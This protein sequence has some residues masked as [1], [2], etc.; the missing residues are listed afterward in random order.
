MVASWFS[1]MK[2]GT[3][4]LLFAFAIAASAIAQQ[5]PR[6]AQIKVSPPPDVSNAVQLGHLDTATPLH[7]TVSLPY[8]DPGGMQRFVDSVSDPRNPNYR[9]F[10]TPEQIGQRFGLPASVVAKV[11]DYLKANGMTVQLVAKNHLTVSANCTVAQAETAFHTTIRELSAADVKLK[12]GQKLYSFTTGLS[13]PV[14]IAPYIIDVSGLET[15]TRPHAHA[16][17]SPDQ[18]R[19]L[20]GVAPTYAAKFQGKG[21]TVGITSFDGFELSNV[22]LLYQQFSL[23]TPAGGVGS[24]IKVETSNASI[25]GQNGP[26]QGEGDLDIQC[27]LSMASLCNLI[28]YDGGN[29]AGSWDPTGILALEA[30]DNTCDAISES[31]LWHG[32]ASFYTTQHNHHLAFNAQG[33]TYMACSGDHG[34][35]G[36]AKLPYPSMD[37]EIL[38]VGGTTIHVDATGNRISETAWNLTNELGD[39]QLWG[40]GG[41]WFPST[42]AFNVTPPYQKGKGVPTSVPFRLVPDVALDADFSYEI[43]LNGVFQPSQGIAWGGTSAATPTFTGSL[44]DVEERLISVNALST[45]AN[46]KQRLGRINDLLYLQNGNANVLFDI[47]TGNIGALPDGSTAVAT[48]GWDFTSG[49]GA[50]NFNGLYNLLATPPTVKA[51]TIAPGSVEGGS[52]TATGT[53]TLTGPALTDSFSVS[54]KSSS[55]LAQVP[56]KVTLGFGATSIP[57]TIKTKSV[58]SST[59]VTITATTGTVSKTATLT[60]TPPA[61]SA[62]KVVPTSV[63]GGGTSVGTVSIP[64]AAPVG[65]TVVTLTSGNSAATVPA[66][67]TIA[68]GSESA[69][70]NVTTKAVTASTAVKISASG[71]GKTATATL[72]LLPL[73][74]TGLTVSATSLFAKGVVTGTVKISGAA[75]ATGTTV[76]LTLSNAALGTLSTTGVKVAAGATSVTFTFTAKPV[77]ASTTETIK[78]TLGG[79]SK[80]ASVTIKPAILSAVTSSATSVLGGVQNATITFTLNA[81]AGPSGTVVTVKSSS[82]AATFAVS[83]VKVASGST[84]AKL[85]LTS[86]GVAS[87]TNVTV[88]G[89]ATASKTVVVKVTAALLTAFTITPSS[90]QGNGTKL[91]TGKLTLNGPTGAT[92]R[93]VT[94]TSSSASA[95]LPA[96]VSIPAGAKTVSFTFAPKAVAATTTATL[97]AKLASVSL[98][99]SLTITH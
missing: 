47:T 11:S 56:A 98:T 35:P 28:V 64:E 74:V 48:A 96:S 51:F 89:T 69:T 38:S 55:S 91:V 71:G 21:R 33:I 60:L 79:V 86:V 59:I 52:G 87:D 42:D 81:P 44:V 5:A 36:L 73:Q 62:L 63:I 29:L 22:P 50:V 2:K 30:N 20:Y 16:F 85:T 84:S 75:P 26:Q 10:L 61:V 13:V 14:T 80:T 45:D 25:A 7:I 8:A 78:A 58:P 19:T 76:P 34:A 88:T 95:G 65:G 46:G 17:A 32:G 67:V 43:F 54:L 1:L 41:G 49:L 27:V 90:I 9:H 93:V 23:P 66:T 94:L 39:G 92:A 24:N 12:P 68:A 15:F 4:S 77:D 97:T 3:V 57:F 37:P 70:F 6:V 82:T 83:S 99:Q 40:G 18:L 72:T 53:L 31:Y